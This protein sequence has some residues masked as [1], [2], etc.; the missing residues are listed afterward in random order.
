MAV[1]GLLFVAFAV[2]AVGMA[3]AA[4]NGAQS[5]ADASALAAAQSYRDQVFAGFLRDA[6]TAD[7]G[8][9]WLTGRADPPDTACA[10][11]DRLAAGNDADDEGCRV[12]TGPGP[13]T[14]FEVT[15][16]TRKAV[17]K[18]VVPGTEDIHA[19]AVA[20]AVVEPRCSP[21]PGDAAPLL[22]VCDDGR[23]LAVDPQHLDPLLDAKALFAVRLAATDQ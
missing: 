11:A 13:A 9:R 20:R 10:E 8:R 18:S 4:R 23:Q 21:K 22:L 16:R 3:G 7:A 15:V 14:S 19:R 17:G 12:T 5:A 1:A 6:G 2:F